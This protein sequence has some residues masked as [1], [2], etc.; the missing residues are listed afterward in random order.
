ML[1][2]GDLVHDLS[3]KASTMRAGALIG[4]IGGVAILVGSAF[5]YGN[6]E[7]TAMDAIYVILIASG[8]KLVQRNT[9]ARQAMH[10]KGAK[11]G[12]KPTKPG[13]ELE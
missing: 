10:E 7:V 5:G 6:V 13:K 1:G 9:E 2:L 4:W 11:L 8:A 3:G 12:G